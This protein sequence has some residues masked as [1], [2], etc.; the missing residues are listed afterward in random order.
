MEPLHGLAVSFLTAFCEVVNVKQQL[1][2][3]C[4]TAG[5]QGE[6]TLVV[7]VLDEARSW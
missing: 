6:Q 1:A 2:F 5:E 3:R 7:R 4:V